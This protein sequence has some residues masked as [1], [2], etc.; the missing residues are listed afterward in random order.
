M[1]AKEQRH[2]WKNG[3]TK[4]MENIK[5]KRILIIEDEAIVKALELKFQNAGFKVDVA[6]DGI[7]A[8][9][10]LHASPPDIAL[11]DL[12]LPDIDGFEVLKKIRADEYLRNIPVLVFS[13][14][15][16]PAGI[17]KVKSFGVIGYVIKADTNLSDLV[18]KISVYF[19]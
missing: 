13:N 17:E 16:D 1:S 3:R 14:L 12:L 8:M 4:T 11:L 6:R 5:P 15:S 18:E 19:K 2:W 7:E 9:E 10:K